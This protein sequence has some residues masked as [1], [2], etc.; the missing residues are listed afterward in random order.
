MTDPKAA[1][2]WE[3]AEALM[4]W[5]NT[6][7]SLSVPK[8]DI[9]AWAMAYRPERPELGTLVDADDEIL[10]VAAIVAR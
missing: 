3:C 9:Y 7:E 1:G 5:L 2:G 6:L 10:A 8:T 4:A